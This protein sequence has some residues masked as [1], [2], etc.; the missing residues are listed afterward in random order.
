M[1]Q[2]KKVG[3]P[4]V[5]RTPMES[6]EGRRMLVASI[7]V[8]AG[9]AVQIVSGDYAP[10]RSDYT[11]IGPATLSGG[12]GRATRSF[13]I[14]NNGQSTMNLTGKR[15]RVVG[16]NGD[17]FVVSK[18]PAL[19]IA[20]G[21]STVFRVQFDPS[22]TGNKLGTVRITSDANNRRTFNF[23]IQ[24]QGYSAVD[25]GDGLRYGI[26]QSGTGA[27]AQNNWVLQMNYTGFRTDGLV[28]DSS[29]NPGRDPFDFGLGRGQVIEGWDRGLVG[30]KL[31]E[32]RVLFIPSALG[33]GST[34]SGQNIPPNTDLIFE[35][36]TLA[37]GPSI[38]VQGRNNTVVPDGDTSPRTADGT[39]FGSVA[40]SGNNIVENSFTVFAGL[41]AT[42]LQPSLTGNPFVRV[43][44][45]NASD[46][47][48][49]WQGNGLFKVT[50]NP[51][52]TGVRR[53]RIEILNNN[54]SDGTYNFD[55]QGT[56]T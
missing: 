3:R 23:G 8:E 35:T 51:S 45:T 42:G 5:S 33:Y 24:G 41:S 18:R 56:G 47:S 28:F 37:F 20:P 53:A 13:V 6:L 27:G 40:A 10:A 15:V 50:F 30:T 44:G 9:N 19:T 36:Q 7:S 21:G 4:S 11:D 14:K 55:I 22:S 43:A 25:V 31:G 16:D 54:P 2:S 1:S 32:R 12:F 34:G 39:D 26:I 46:F 52:A 49:E 29:L 38:E 48:V 17:Q